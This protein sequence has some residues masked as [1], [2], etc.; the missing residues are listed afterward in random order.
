MQ[1]GNEVERKHWVLGS[2]IFC[3]HSVQIFLLL[4]SSG[5]GHDDISFEINIILNQETN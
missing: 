4:F 3:K 1:I 2:D 5:K